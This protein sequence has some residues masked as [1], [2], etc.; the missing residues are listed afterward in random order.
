MLEGIRGVVRRVIES[1]LLALGNVLDGSNS[2][3]ILVVVKFAVGCDRVI[4]K[5]AQWCAYIAIGKTLVGYMRDAKL[6]ALE[7]G[8]LGK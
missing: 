5:G 6:G 2:Y 1:E 8:R 7:Q 4:N 3:N